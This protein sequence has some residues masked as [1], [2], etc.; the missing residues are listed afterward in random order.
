MYTRERCGAEY[1]VRDDDYNELIAR[2]RDAT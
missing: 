1:K 2:A